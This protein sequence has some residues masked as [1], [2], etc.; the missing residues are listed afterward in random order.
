[1]T[2]MK[3]VGEPALCPATYILPIAARES[4]SRRLTGYLRRLSR[5]VDEVIVVD[6]SDAETFRTHSAAW[7][8][9]VRHLPPAIRTSN[10]KVAGVM[11]G[12]Y[13]AQ[14]DYLIIADDDVRYRKSDLLHVVELLK[15]FDVVRPQN[16]FVPLPWH[17]RWDT[18]RSLLNRVWG[19]DWPGTLGV[20][21]LTLL[22]S[23]GYS[24]EVLFENLELVRTVQSV[25]GQEAVPLDLF[26][27]RRPPTS[28]H[29]FAQRVRQAYDEFARPARMIVQ[30]AMLPLACCALLLQPSL[31]PWA[32]AELIIT[33]EIGRRKG[34][35]SKVFPV[36]SALWS[37]AWAAERS[38]A[39]WAALG[40]RLIFGGIKYRTT[41]LRHAAT[42]LAVLRRRMVRKGA[43]MA[44]VVQQEP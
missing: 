21:R 19:G 41:S 12:L 17:A 20:R 8:G 42:P 40:I 5:I 33:A 9:F 38:V 28:S 25:G 7:S 26:V 30:L 16:F 2:I 14:H 34:V 27:P 4:Q 44:R 29:F 36:T 6:G 18:A 31:L 11:T 3:E 39:I 10:G 23:G 13:S 1:M 37:V 24:G 15:T 43:V 32:G 35:G 22:R